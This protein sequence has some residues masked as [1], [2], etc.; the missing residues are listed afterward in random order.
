M[1]HRFLIFA[2]LVVVAVVLA[3][4]LSTFIPIDRQDFAPQ[5]SQSLRVE[6]RH[7]ILLRAFLNEKEEWGE[8]KPVDQISPLLVQAT[9]AVED[10]RFYSHPGI[11]PAGIFRAFYDNVRALRF[12]SGGS[13]ITQQVI[14][15]VHRR[16]RSLSGKFMEL[17]EATRLERSFSKKEI[18]EQ[19]LNRAPYGNQLT[20]VQSAALCYF[21]KTAATVS[22]AEAAYLAALPNA[23]SSLNPY[24]NPEGALRRQRIVLE[25]MR[26]QGF[27]SQ[28][29]FDRAIVQPVTINPREA[30]FRTPHVVAMVARE[31]SAIPGA[32]V[33][34]TTID[35]SLQEVVQ[36]LLRGHLASLS[37]KNVTNGAVVIIENATGA[38]RT[39]VGSADFFDERIQG[40]VNG[41]TALRQPGS[42]IKPLT[43]SLALASGETPAT[44]IPDLPLH[45]PDKNGDYI[46]ENYDRRFHGPVRLRTALACSYN[47]PAVRMLQRVGQESLLE[48]IRSAGITSVTESAEYYGFGLTLGNAEVSLLELTNAYATLAR[49]GMWK[50]ATIIGEVR[51]HQNRLIDRPPVAADRQVIDRKVAFLVADILSDP[52]ARRPAFGNAFHFPFSCA[53]KTG[54][55]KE[56]R[57]NWTIGFTT[58]YTV[59]VWVGNFD[60]SVMRG[61]SGMTG[62]G[63]VFSDVML[64]LVGKYSLPGG[65]AVP[66]GLVK[67]AICPRSG[68]LP[69]RDCQNSVVE[70]FIKGTAPSQRCDE[71]QRFQFV[72]DDGSRKERVF[73]V[74]PA[75]YSDWSAEQHIAAPPPQAVRVR[76][77]DN[78]IGVNRSG[79]PLAI[80]LPNDGDIYK[81]DPTLRPEYQTVKVVGLIGNGTSGVELEVDGISRI[82][83]DSRGTW[84]QLQRGT[85]TLKLHGTRNQKRIASRTVTIHVE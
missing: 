9:V 41:A 1:K 65:F 77:G 36:S 64:Y 81:I 4:F 2:P 15:S 75:E 20:G 58:D 70:W 68:M 74:L 71:H 79:A 27:I 55:T 62:A 16:P 17:W 45:L 85:H 82:P 43:Y 6:D 31:L 78:R 57:D 21:G 5:A 49:Q 83:Y 52:R 40:Q 3:A 8:W 51:D 66:P 12:V 10:K 44:I 54:T 46:P 38:V 73:E 39:L 35:Y 19:Y 72:D 13:T 37:K 67:A 61:V 69:T 29:E 14:R 47:I 11:D 28:S 56:Y 76:T 22:L 30:V 33:A 18:L 60:G 84:W 48:L 25:R 7:G 63:Q 32:A 80:I 59:G 24:K 53:V 42:A 50:P 23:P 34:H 26:E